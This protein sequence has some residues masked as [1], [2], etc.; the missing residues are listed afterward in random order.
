VPGVPHQLFCDVLLKSLHIITAILILLLLNVAYR[1][2][3][4]YFFPSFLEHAG[5]TAPCSDLTIF[6]HSGSYNVVV[7]IQ[8]SFE[9]TTLSKLSIGVHFPEIPIISVHSEGPWIIRFQHSIIQTGK[10]VAVTSK[11]IDNYLLETPYE[12]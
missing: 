3:V 9:V 4:A 8:V 5:R 11:T 7:S 12:K 6:V 1:V 10:H 2:D